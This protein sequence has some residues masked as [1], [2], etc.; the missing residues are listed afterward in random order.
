MTAHLRLFASSL[1][2]V[3]LLL[4]GW[5]VRP[6]AAQLAVDASGNGKV[7]GIHCTLLTP[8]FPTCEVSGSGTEY[9]F[10]FSGPVGMDVEGIVSIHDPDTGVRVQSVAVVGVI[11]E[12][13]KFVTWSGMCQVTDMLGTLVGPC[14]GQAA[15]QGEPGSFDVALFSYDVGTSFGSGCCQYLNGG[16]QIKD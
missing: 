2:A 9:R 15:D 12:Q 5:D 10:K 1:L 7:P 14:S 6:V 16:A 11:N 4:V 3:T 8:P 13:F